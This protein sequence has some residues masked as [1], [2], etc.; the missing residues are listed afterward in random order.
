MKL[1]L[2]GATGFVGSFCH[3]LL[4]EAGYEVIG[5]A[6]DPEDATRRFPDR[7]FVH[8]DVAD[9]SSVAQAVRGVGRALYLVHGMKDSA[10]YG[11]AE[12]LAAKTFGE[13]ADRAGLDRIV[14][15]GG[16]RPFGTISRHLRS[17]LET[18]ETLRAGR[19]PVAELQASMIVGGGSESF[20]MVRDLA[21]R[22]PAMILPRWSSSRTQPIGIRDVGAAIRFAL[23]MPLGRSEVFAVPGPEI[24]AAGEIIR[25]TAWLLGNDPLL[26]HVPF[27]S[28]RLSSYWIRFVTRTN[29]RL[30][31][32]LVEGLR[33]DVLSADAGLWRRMPGYQRQT[34]A[35]A[36]AIAVEEEAKE[37]GQAGRRWEKLVNRIA[38]LRRKQLGLGSGAPGKQAV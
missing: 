20:R 10:D 4:L 34:F 23:D 17:R 29:G 5:G 32:E 33:S 28:P 22:L 9:R 37:V 13:E 14:Y 27:L 15:L 25:R 19:T 8:F 16:L 31:T 2:T 35:E 24:L 36:A 18:G 26:I 30:A 12:V 3:P 1:L 6:R 7:E 11:R 38:P 21:A